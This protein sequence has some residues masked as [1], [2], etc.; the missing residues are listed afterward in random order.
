MLKGKSVLV[1]G[2]TGSLGQQLVAQLIV[3]GNTVRVLSRNEYFQWEMQKNFNNK[4]IRYFIG[5]VRDRER[6]LRAFQ[7]VDVVIHTAAL[8]HVSSCEYN[9]IEAVKTNIVGSINVIEAAL[10]RGVEKVLAVSSDKSVNPLNIYGATK[11]CMEKLFINAN[12][13]GSKFSC[14]RCGNF[15]GSSGS[16]IPLFQEQASTGTLTVTDPK[17]TRYFIDIEKVASFVIQ[18]AEIME[19]G[20]IFVPDMKEENI[21]DLAKSFHCNIEITGKKVG[22]KLNEEI[23][24]DDESKKAVKIE[25]GWKC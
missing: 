18:C 22:E 24:T 13:Y 16:V 14:V 2:G 4:A 23:M 7:N 9:P 10:D 25:G 3:N 19:G 1:T 8:K 11:L 17:M 5:D 6:L 20:E 15:S 21:M 12:S